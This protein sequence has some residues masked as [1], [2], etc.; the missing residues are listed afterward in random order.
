MVKEIRLF[1]EGDKKG[2]EPEFRKAFRAFFQELY[3]QAEQNGVRFHPPFM[4]GS[5]R[6]AF[7]AF[8]HALKSPDDT[9]VVL[10]IDSDAP[11]AQSRLQHLKQ[12]FRW[13]DLP[14]VSEAQCHFMAQM[15]ESWF[16]ADAETLAGYYERGFKRNRIPK[17]LNV[18]QVGKDE[19]LKALSIASEETSKG[20]Y[21]KTRHAP[22]ILQRLKHDVVRKKAPHC[23]VLFQTLADVING[24]QTKSTPQK[25]RKK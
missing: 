6:E 7:K 3:K 24:T 13:D 18:E 23:E 9:F 20:K 25:R 22:E 16:I 15:M 21:H 11:V 19:V 2:H 12:H 17:S 14:K 5:G 8:K 10:L 1:I 4:A